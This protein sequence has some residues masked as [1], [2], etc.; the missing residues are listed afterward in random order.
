MLTAARLILGYLWGAG[1]LGV[2]LVVWRRPVPVEAALTRSSS[3]LNG[4][5][6]WAGQL[7]DAVGQ[8][9]LGLSVW[10]MAGGVFVFLVMVADVVCPRVPMGISGF[11]K[12][13]TGAAAW[14][15]LGWSVLQGAALMW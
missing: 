12:T 15:A 8:I 6:A 7:S 3:G 9:V 5:A 11:A 13:F 1:L 4:S 14:L 2:G 10:A